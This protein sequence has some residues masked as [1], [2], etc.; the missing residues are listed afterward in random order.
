MKLLLQRAGR[1][2]RHRDRAI[3][4]LIHLLVDDEQWERHYPLSDDDPRTPLSLG[5]AFSGI[6]AQRCGTMT[7]ALGAALIDTSPIPA[8]RGEM[9][10]GVALRGL[11][12]V[13][14]RSTNS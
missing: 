14:A 5:A 1:D 4:H 2:R 6:C 12:E 13:A 9:S 10:N 7:R 8:R 11:S 3:W